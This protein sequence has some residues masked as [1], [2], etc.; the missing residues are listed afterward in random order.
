MKFRNK[1]DLSY[2]SDDFECKINKFIGIIQACGMY[3]VIL[4]ENDE[5]H[6]EVEKFKIILYTYSLI[7]AI[8]EYKKHGGIL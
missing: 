6:E 3:G 5:N 7:K 8:E 2:Y 1:T 4:V